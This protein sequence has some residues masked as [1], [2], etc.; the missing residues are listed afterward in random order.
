LPA[1]AKLTVDGV[2]T[3]QTSAVRVFITPALQEG[4]EYTY[5]LKA[6]IVRDG[7]TVE[8]AKTVKVIAGGEHDVNFATEAT[9]VASR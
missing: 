5:N 9:N 4:R 2:A 7:Q 6:Q 1:D 3:V 8:I